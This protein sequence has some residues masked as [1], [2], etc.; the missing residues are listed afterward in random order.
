LERVGN[1]GPG[2]KEKR[3]VDFGKKEE[4]FAERKKIAGGHYEYLRVGI[5]QKSRGD[6]RIE[7]ARGLY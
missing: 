6:T 4:L 2:I 3:H 5:F 1:E 7:K